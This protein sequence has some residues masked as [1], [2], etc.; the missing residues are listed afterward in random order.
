MLPDLVEGKWMASHATNRPREPVHAFYDAATLAAAVPTIT[1]ADFYTHVQPHMA[2]LSAE[3]HIRDYAYP[4]QFA[5]A[6][7]SYGLVSTVDPTQ[8]QQPRSPQQL[9]DFLV[10]VCV[11][12]CVLC[13]YAHTHIPVLYLW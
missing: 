2:G 6:G 3:L 10:C 5:F 8:A 9:V 11:C 12:V 13:I 4:G 1:E 7:L